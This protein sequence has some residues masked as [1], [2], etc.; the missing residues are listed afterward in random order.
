MINIQNFIEDAISQIKE[1]I[2]TF[3]KESDSF[4]ASYPD[5]ITFELYVNNEMLIGGNHKITIEVPLAYYSPK[6]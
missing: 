6:E 3:N 5:N 4:K 2:I 1:G